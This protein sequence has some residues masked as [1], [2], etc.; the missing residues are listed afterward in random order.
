MSP[1]KPQNISVNTLNGI[2]TLSVINALSISAGV[3][4]S[5][6]LKARFG[7][8]K[9]IIF[10]FMFLIVGLAGGGAVL[11]IFAVGTIEVGTVLV[12]VVGI[13]A[14][15]AVVGAVRLGTAFATGLLAILVVDVRVVMKAVGSGTSGA[16]LLLA[17]AGI[18]TTGLFLLS[19]Y[20]E[21][22]INIK[23]KDWD[24]SVFRRLSNISAPRVAMTSILAILAFSIIRTDVS[25][26]YVRLIRGGEFILLLFPVLN[27]YADCF[28]VHETRL[29]LKLAGKWSLW[30][31]P[32]LLVGD[33]LLSGALFAVIPLV[34]TSWTTIW[35]AISFQG[36]QPYLGIFFWST[37]STSAMFYLF[38]ASSLIVTIF[39]I[40]IKGILYSLTR[41]EI[42]KFIIH[43]MGFVLVLLTCAGFGTWWLLV[44][45]G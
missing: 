19:R 24:E 14:A 27:L 40:P 16:G 34:S 22:K 38:M 8:D 2:L 37:F 13:G 45:G 7:S 21:N 18:A 26:E 41:L 15:G 32:I 17:V 44:G 9:K 5:D 23:S 29:V 12:T 36:E 43:S 42:E 33:L 6:M 30:L 1:A 28:S 31:L 35:Q 25:L 10:D 3:K 11:V 4:L 20:F 39:Y